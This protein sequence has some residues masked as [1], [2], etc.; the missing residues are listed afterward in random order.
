MLLCTALVTF[1]P[2]MRRISTISDRFFHE[3]KCSAVLLMRHGERNC[4]K[5][6]ADSTLHVYREL[7]RECL[8]LANYLHENH[9]CKLLAALVIQTRVAGA[10]TTENITLMPKHALTT[11]VIQPKV[12]RQHNYN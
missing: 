6:T 8:L 7:Y 12:Q 2:L 1:A 3:A 10:Q 9:I 11:M 5:H 4:H